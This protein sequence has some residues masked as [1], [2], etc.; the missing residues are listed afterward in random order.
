M[1]LII[2][3]GSQTTHLI[4]RRIK[5]LGVPVEIAI[6]KN[7]LSSALK[8]KP[9]GIILSG[10]PAS[11]YGKNA[12]LVDGK[13][14]KLGVPVLGIC[15]G[16]EVMGQMLGGQ[17]APGKKKEYG[18]TSF[19]LTKNNP[20][21]ANLG[22]NKNTFTVWMSHFDQVIK[23][24]TDSIVVGSTPDVKIAAFANVK[25]KQYGIMFH[26]EV[27]H[28]QYG[29][30]IL[31]NF[32]INICGEV[33]Q[34]R[35][36]NTSQLI[37]KIKL[38]IGA[39]KAVC[40]LSGGID[41]A[42]AA[43]LTHEAIGDKLTCFY[44]DTGLMRL[45]ETDQIT[46]TFKVHFKLKL[47]VIHAED[48]FLSA[49]KGITDPEE[50]RKIIG[51]TFIRIFEKEAQKLGTKYLVQG[52]IYPD[53]IESKGTNHAHK[54][55]THHNVGGIPE[56]HGFKIIEP[57]RQFY[58]DEVREIAK[59]LGF[60]G[61]IISRH[62]FPGPGL[63]VRIIGEITKEKLD[64][65][66]RADAIVVDELRKAGLYEKIWMGFAVFTGVK[67]TGVTGDERKYGE[68]IALRII[69]SKD[70]MTAD[71]ARLPYELLERISSRI[72]T[73]VFEVVRVVYDITTK[74]PATMEWE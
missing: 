7:A 24:P 71:W 14:F 65:L 36:I 57:L 48:I 41:S 6:P 33:S 46:Q 74:P 1:I 2:D 27:H 29:N 31:S 26:P 47:Q 44:V 50:K 68:T 70:T 4:G 37:K 13:I 45:G 54:I 10:G 5:D 19:T 17:V 8:I 69:E 72:V 35:N 25:K 34:K 56:K 61:S 23:V 59:E 9:R 16:L 43:V 60:P 66:R 52:T 67:S 51:E 22:K 55:K 62:V 30:Q 53:V 58:K 28:T 32:I 11:T 21:F 15:Y 40:A 20:L 3:F 38:E 12:L 73:E 64:I 39:Q 63:A 18:S 49:L 42:V